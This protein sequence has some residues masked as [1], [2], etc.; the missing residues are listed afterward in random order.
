M[1]PNLSK[2][3]T[4]V[5]SPTLSPSASTNGYAPKKSS[6]LLIFFVLTV[7]IGG[8]F[9]GILYVVYKPNVSFLSSLLS[10]KQSSPNSPSELKSKAEKYIM[11]TDLAN[12][13]LIQSFVMYIYR[14]KITKVETSPNGMPV[15]FTDSSL[16]GLPNR[17]EYTT[18]T[19][20]WTKPGQTPTDPS[21]L[22]IGSTVDLSIIYTLKSDSHA[23][24][25]LTLA[26]VYIYPN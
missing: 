18:K 8:L 13:N 7:L 25:Q 10:I 26:Y 15:I 17:W 4:P 14:G 23:I 9:L 19:V 22:K 12:P 11:Q 20:T 3:E 5:V 2:V 24:D 21:A 16:P 1:D 6:P